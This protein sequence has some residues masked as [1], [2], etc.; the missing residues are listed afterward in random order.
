MNNL[1]KKGLIKKF[2]FQ[3]FN[4]YK[5]IMMFLNYIY[6]KLK[7]RHQKEDH[8]FI[9]LFDFLQVIIQMMIKRKKKLI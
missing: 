2:Y 6:K 8:R 1:I 5:M 3:N 4:L 7:K 9:N